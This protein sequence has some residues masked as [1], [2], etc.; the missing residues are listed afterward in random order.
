MSHTDFPGLAQR[1]EV[2]SIYEEAL[3]YQL[4]KDG[5]T[6]ER[7]VPIKVFYDGMPLSSELRLDLLV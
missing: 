2:E 6:V 3:V 4:R 5:M 7:Q 1:W